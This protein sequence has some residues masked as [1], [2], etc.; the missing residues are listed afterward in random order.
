MDLGR[1]T[2]IVCSCE[3]TMA[4]D[5]ATVGRGCGADRVKTARQ[6]CR[7]ELDLFRAEAGRGGAVLVGCTQEAPLFRE[8][9]EEDGLAAKLAFA[10]IRQNRRLFQGRRA[11]RHPRMWALIPAG[12]RWIFPPPKVLPVDPRKG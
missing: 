3:D 8:I 12:Q 6:L 7:G 2:V 1:A 4:P 10:N 11:P 9:V 5:A